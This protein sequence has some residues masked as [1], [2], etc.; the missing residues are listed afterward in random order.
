MVR[1]WTAACGSRS[2]HVGRSASLGG[3][4]PP[5]DAPAERYVVHRGARMSADAL[6]LLDAWLAPAGAGEP[7]ACIATTF[8]FDPDFFEEECLARFLGLDSAVLSD[9]GTA[10]AAYYVVQREEALEE[11]R[12]TV[13]VDRAEAS[14]ATSH[15]WD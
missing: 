5:S 13:L 14:A 15:R 9:T 2:V 11:A 3:A 6:R 10:D 4:L 12:A 7:V 8:T 1:A